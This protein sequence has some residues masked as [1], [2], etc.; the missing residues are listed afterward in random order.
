MMPRYTNQ[1]VAK[2]FADIGDL[3]EIKGENRFKILAYRKAADNIAGLGQDLFDL[4]ESGQD[5]RKIEGIG[6]AIAD[7]SAEL[8]STGRLEFWEKLTAEV[9]VSLVEVLNIPDV[10][11]KLAKSMWQELGLTTVA[12]VKAAA[13]A[14]RLQTLPRMGAKSEARILASIE[15]LERRETGR[16]HLGIA[17]PLA[18][19]VMAVLDNLP[20]ALKVE[21]A[22]S[23]RRMRETIGD[24][25][26]LVATENPRP[27]MAA[28]KDLAD[29]QEVIAAGETKTSVRFKNGLQ[30]DLR[31]L[32]PSRWGTALQYFTG[33]QAHN[34][35][36]RELAQKQGY[37][38]NEYALTRESDGEKLMFDN[39]V[40][41]YEFLGMDYIPPLL[42]EDRG[43]IKAAQNHT[44]PALLKVGDIKG[45]VHCHSTWSD[46]ADSIE[47]MARAALARGYEY[48]VISD[49]S[50]SLGIANGL[51]PER[52]RQQRREIDEVQARL[53]GIRLLQ[54]TEME[55]KADGTLDFADE[56]L[57]ELDFVVASV[58]TGLRQDR[59]TLTRRTLAA[60]NNP[61]VHLIGHPSGRLL[62]QREAG[63]FDMEA[64]MQAAAAT[65]T[66][67]EI[68]ASPER[69][70][71]SDAHVRRA[72]EL[73]VKLMIN[74]DAH[75]TDGFENLRFGVAT[76]NRGWATA[77]TILNTRS[78]REIEAMVMKA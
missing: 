19:Q 31:C 54:G 16:V 34:V 39:E 73:G 26:F 30:A 44:L 74:C 18:R 9:P 69:L 8:F 41:L 15:A 28:F 6:Q 42:R 38:L 24:L 11:P 47:A 55:I 48:L 58:H 78:W 71:L 67:L 13:Q 2:L 57:A 14:G 51:T 35:K 22:G 7:K 72:V 4:W 37:S 33:S 32:E 27:I 60:I 46:G 68:N 50:Q 66:A 23:L 20:D 76:A 63:D 40:E 17:W 49:H 59:E 1:E 12:E 77:E 45:E 62:T 70:D 61:Y 29:V 25:D 36:V 5:L 52:L 65:G 56:V 10:G 53:P 3:L 64:I 21:V 75:H 43:E